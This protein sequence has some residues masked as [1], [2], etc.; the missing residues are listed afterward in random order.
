MAHAHA[1]D[2]TPTLAGLTELLPPP[3]KYHPGALGFSGAFQVYSMFS[4]YPSIL[5][6]RAQG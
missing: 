1:P 6:L 2:C 5:L 3:I 4:D